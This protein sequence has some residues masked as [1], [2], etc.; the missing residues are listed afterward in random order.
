MNTARDWKIP[1]SEIGS[2]CG[3]DDEI[4]PGVKGY[5]IESVGRLYLP[6]VFS[7]RPSAF[8]EFLRLCESYE[9]PVVFASVINPRLERL[10]KVRGWIKG[11]CFDGEADEHTDVWSYKKEYYEKSDSR[12]FTA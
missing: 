10:L 5:A 9:P 12:K 11:V 2:P 6:L 4:Y 1:V 3:F 7:E 8:L